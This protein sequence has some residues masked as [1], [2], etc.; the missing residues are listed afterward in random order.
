MKNIFL[1]ISANKITI[2]KRTEKS[3]RSLNW[4]A[5]ILYILWLIT[6]FNFNLQFALHVYWIV[7]FV[8][9]YS[10]KDVTQ[11]K[12]GK[13]FSEVNWR[14]TLL[15]INQTLLQFNLLFLQSLFKLMIIHNDYTI[16]RATDHTRVRL[17]RY[18]LSKNCPYRVQGGGNFSHKMCHVFRLNLKS[19][20][21]ENSAIGEFFEL[22]LN[23]LPENLR[24]Q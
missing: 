1:I 24:W 21:I 19:T 7:K 10:R 15:K 4:R 17:L 14:F 3:Y 22:I 6:Q 8:Y 12:F 5:L 9:N 16:T 23:D 2:I 20:F 13:F 18:I 11:L